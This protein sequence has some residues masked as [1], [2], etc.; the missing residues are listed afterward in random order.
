MS[1]P[2]VTALIVALAGAIRAFTPDVLALFQW[3]QSRRQPQARP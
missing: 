2:E 1:V 3:L